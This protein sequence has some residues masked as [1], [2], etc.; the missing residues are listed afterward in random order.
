MKKNIIKIFTAVSVAS[1]I[2][3]SPIRLYTYIKDKLIEPDYFHIS[4][5]G[6]VFYYFNHFSM[7]EIKKWHSDFKKSKSRKIPSIEEW[8]RN[9]SYQ[10]TIK[11]G[12]Q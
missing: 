12:K 9:I 4:A 3:V 5:K 7:R 6:I 11:I 10:S 2:K 8:R 1:E